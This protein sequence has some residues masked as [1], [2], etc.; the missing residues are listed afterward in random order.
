[1]RHVR[2]IVISLVAFAARIARIAHMQLQA[3]VAPIRSTDEREPTAIVIRGGRPLIG[4]VS[5]AGAKNALGKQLVASLLTDEPCNFFNVPDITEIHTILAMLRSVG[6]K[7]D[8]KADGSLTVHTPHLASAQVSEQYSGFNR[9][10]VLMLGPLLHREKQVRV[11]MLGGCKIGQRPVDFH[12]DA[13]ERLG[14]KI[15][16]DEQG[17]TATASNLRG[18][19]I[20]LPYPSVGATENI[21]LSATLA[22]GTTI[23]ENAAV[24]PEIIDTITFLV[25][26]GASILVDVDRRIIIRGVNKLHG[27]SHAPIGDRIEAASYAVAAAA[28]GGRVTV[29]GIHIEHMLSFLHHFRQMGGD[30]E[31][32]PEGLVFFRKGD[33]LKPVQIQTDVHPGFMTDWQQPLVVALT[34]AHGISVVHETVYENRFGYTEML[35]KMGA[36]ISTVTTCLGQKQCRFHDRDHP[37]SAIINGPTPLSA[38]EIDIPDLRAGFAYVIA[39]LLAPGETRIGGYHY[40]ARG[41]ANV[42]EKLGALGISVEL[43][44]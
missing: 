36:K 3:P 1:M 6:T 26:M 9:I 2:S 31:A 12:L 28:T 42:P 25:K 18:A 37:H 30:F 4:R 33:S 22:T 10:P 16:T 40:L 34:Q 38:S 32:H 15:E 39:G 8:R 29:E 14:A 13:L 27:A 11:P 17:F 19:V 23:I 24:E 21:L 35:S 41:Y 20:R 5:V 44:Y 43:L 7:V